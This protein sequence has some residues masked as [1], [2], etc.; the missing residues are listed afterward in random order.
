MLVYSL[1]TICVQHF[2]KYGP[3]NGARPWLDCRPLRTLSISCGADRCLEPPRSR[4]E[5]LQS[6]LRLW[7]EEECRV[8][9]GR[10]GKPS[11]APYPLT[12]PPLCKGCFELKIEDTSKWANMF[13]GGS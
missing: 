7:P 1:C 13:F 9:Q 8:V 11:R 5:T 2:H 10:G 4:P 3:C 12:C 6:R